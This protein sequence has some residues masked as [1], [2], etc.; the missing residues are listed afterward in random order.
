MFM[1]RSVMAAMAALAWVVAAG[2]AQAGV[3]VSTVGDRDGFGILAANG[4]V[5]DVGFIQA[6][7]G[8]GTDIFIDGPVDY[9]LGSVVTGSVLA[10]RLEIFSAGWGAVGPVDVRLNGTV[11]GQLTDGED[12]LGVSTAHLDVFNLSASQL[13]LLT[14][15]DVVSIDPGFIDPALGI[16]ADSGVVDYLQLSI[17]DDSVVELPEP[18]S[19]GLVGVALLAAAG[20]ATRVRRQAR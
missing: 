14:G 20:A 13:L 15:N 8:D 18:A 7:D 9:A 2:A 4:D 19:F 1:K 5:V 6:G 11:I 10:A 3:L 12:D 17:T 16:L